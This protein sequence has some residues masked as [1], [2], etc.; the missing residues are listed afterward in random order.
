MKTEKTGSNAQRAET[1]DSEAAQVMKTYEQQSPYYQGQTGKRRRGS[2][3]K[4]RVLSS[5]NFP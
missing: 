1:S 4:E 5:L 2:A 3:K